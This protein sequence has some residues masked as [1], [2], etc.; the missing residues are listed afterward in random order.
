MFIEVAKHSLN[1]TS[2]NLRLV[3]SFLDFKG[4]FKVSFKKGSFVKLRILKEG[5]I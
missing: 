1:D 4:V 3:P 2:L 5:E